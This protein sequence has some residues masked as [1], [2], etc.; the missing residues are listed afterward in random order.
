MARRLLA[1]AAALLALAAA[2]CGD[3][4]AD[5]TGPAMAMP[6]GTVAMVSADLRPSADD[7]AAADSL[8]ER[9]GAA[10]PVDLAGP[11]G[12]AVAPDAQGRAA[13]FLVP[14]RDGLG[15]NAGALVDAGDEEGALSAARRLRP[16]IRAERERRGGVVRG[17]TGWVSAL[18]RLR[19]Q[20]TAAAAVDRWVVWGDPRA[21]RAAVVAANGRGL[22]ET[23]QFS[24]AVESFR[25]APALVYVDPRPFAR[26][27]TARALDL[28]VSAAGALAD[29]LLGVRF[30]RPVGGA[31][32][33][34]GSSLR[35]DTAAEDGCPVQPLAEAGGA[36][37]A[38]EF[39]AGLPL[40]GVAQRQCKRRD[41]A[42]VVV[43][44]PNGGSLD[45]DRALDWLLPTRV[46]V[47]EGAVSVSARVRSRVAARREMPRL[48]DALDGLPGVRATLRDGN[49]LEVVARERPRLRLILRPDRALVFLGETPGPARGQARE[50]PAY[51]AAVR[52]LGERRLTALL[53]RP[54]PTIDFVATGRP[55]AG[56]ASLGAGARVVIALR[57]PR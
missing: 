35:I 46:A 40:Y 1:G 2:G 20:P 42:P 10:R 38:A 31:V 7:R 3:E 19:D 4:A 36:P 8:A 28:P 6:R 26:V 53:R 14:S 18:A 30:A 27:L 37:G 33:L 16:L 13:A 23:L 48:R 47:Q 49:E 56:S 11:A 55:V 54:V 34:S 29:R 39:V 41:V 52:L 15:L 21:V 50:T 51:R 9:L 45:L 12:R 22:G 24:R 44:L 25:G 5:L 17:G 57:P 43:K 32:A